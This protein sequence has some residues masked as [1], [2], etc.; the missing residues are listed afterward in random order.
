MRIDSISSE[1]ALL[2]PYLCNAKSVSSKPYDEE[3]LTNTGIL[4]TSDQPNTLLNSEDGIVIAKTSSNS[5]SLNQQY[6][7]RLSVLGFYSGP[8]DDNLSSDISKKAIKNFQMVYGLTTNGTLNSTTKSKLSTAYANYNQ[9]YSSSSF[10]TLSSSSNFNLDSTERMNFARTW[11]F[12]KVGMGLTPKQI[13]GVMGNMYAESRFSSDNA[14]NQSYPGDHNSSYSYSANDE[15]A[16]GLIQWK[17]SS[18]K[19]GLL[20]KADVMG[21]SV[22]DINT[23]FAFSKDEMNSSY[24]SPYWSQ[25]KASS[26]VDT[27]SDIFCQNIEVA[28]AGGKST[29]RSYSNTIY[30]LLG[31]N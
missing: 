28:G 13:S 27:V 12:L 11:A 3:N 4:Y 17:S 2:S 7:S 25:I 8:M 19:Q 18:R 23:L 6:Q 10:A 1:A 14:N 24:Y 20:N 31:A 22:S 30:N 21:L 16:Y 15:V 26:S 29:R 5:V 9:I